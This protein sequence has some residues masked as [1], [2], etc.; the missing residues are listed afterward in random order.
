MHLVFEDCVHHTQKYSRIRSTFFKGLKSSMWSV[1]SMVCIF[2]NWERTFFPNLANT[3]CTNYT[4]TYISSV[5]KIHKGGDDFSRKCTPRCFVPF[6]QFK[7]SRYRRTEIRIK[8]KNIPQPLRQPL[9]KYVLAINWELTTN[10]K[11]KIKL[12]FIC[13]NS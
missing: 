8:I 5:G 9:E 13:K 10:S 4:Q 6:L 11:I 12:R 1:V 3:S 7:Q 2:K